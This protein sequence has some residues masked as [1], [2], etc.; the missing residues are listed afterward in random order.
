LSGLGED[1]RTAFEK[2]REGVAQ[3]HQGMESRTKSV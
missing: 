3:R 1:A 2:G